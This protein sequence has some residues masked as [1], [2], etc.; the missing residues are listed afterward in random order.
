MKEVE[1]ASLD[2]LKWS[3][4]HHT[5]IPAKGTAVYRIRALSPAMTGGICQ[6]TSI[7][8]AF[9]RAAS[10]ASLLNRIER[11]AGYFKISKQV[12]QI[13]LLKV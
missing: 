10:T 9:N 6:H 5:Q 12:R 13:Q 2:I 1:Y 8:R 7:A 3:V 4:D 11:D